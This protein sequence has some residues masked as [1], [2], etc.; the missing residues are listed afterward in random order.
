MVPAP[1]PRIW[2]FTRVT[3]GWTMRPF[4]TPLPAASLIR[5]AVQHDA[6]AFRHNPTAVDQL[7]RTLDSALR[8]KAVVGTQVRVTREPNGLLMVETLDPALL[9]A[10]RAQPDAEEERGPALQGRGN[11]A[12][13]QVG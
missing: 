6:P 13:A 7:Q 12:L 3:D 10:L 5:W 8:A 2:T 9:E 4:R 1:L 11:A